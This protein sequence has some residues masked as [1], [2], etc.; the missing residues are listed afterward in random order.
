MTTN[1][2]SYGQR[3]FLL[4]NWTQLKL[5]K[6]QKGLVWFRNFIFFVEGKEEDINSAEEKVIID[7]KPP[8]LPYPSSI[9]LSKKWK[10]V[11]DDICAMSPWDPSANS[12][13]GNHYW[14]ED[15]GSEG[16]KNL[17]KVI[18]SVRNKTRIWTKGRRFPKPMF[19]QLNHPARLPNWTSE[20]IKP[21]KETG[22]D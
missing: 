12:D 1:P 4:R 20:N 14:N 13:G 15:T 9:L 6:K 3:R 7:L 19:F 16:L 17:P 18:Q 22:Q 2:V 5:F 21:L 11:L 10:E 8:W